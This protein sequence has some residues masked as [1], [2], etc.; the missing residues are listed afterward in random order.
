M[1]EKANL[2]KLEIVFFVQNK[3]LVLN[4]GKCKVIFS[5]TVNAGQT[6]NFEDISKFRYLIFRNRSNASD[7]ILY[8]DEYINSIFMISAVAVDSDGYSF[9]SGTIKSYTS[10]LIDFSSTNSIGISE[11]NKLIIVGVY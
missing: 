1:P 7:T 3:F 11:H 4:L 8:R 5:S 10:A 9:V 6:I 2:L